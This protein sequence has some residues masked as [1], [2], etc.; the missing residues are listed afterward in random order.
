[1]NYMPYEQQDFLMHHG[2]EGQRWG[3]R[4]YQ[5]PDG[6]LTNAG[7]QRYGVRMLRTNI[8]KAIKRSLPEEAPEEIVKYAESL[9]YKTSDLVGYNHA[10]MYREGKLGSFNVTFDFSGD[11]GSVIEPGKEL[12]K[13]SILNADKTIKRCEKEYK[14]VLSTI[15][16]AIAKEHWDAVVDDEEYPAEIE[17]LISN[18]QSLKD[19]LVPRDITVSLKNPNLIRMD[20]RNSDGLGL[21]DFLVYYNIDKDSVY[22]IGYAD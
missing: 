1:M 10:Q 20:I 8:K 21:A 2:I 7:R 18:R 14:K 17:E 5:N 4:R 19:G 12:T 11:Y 16:E 15:K 9:G 6:S 13:D 22:N 3:I